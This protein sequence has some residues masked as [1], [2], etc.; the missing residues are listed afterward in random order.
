MR[1]SHDRADTIRRRAALDEYVERELLTSSGAFICEHAATCELSAKAEGRQ[2][3]PGEMPCMG[4]YYSLVDENGRPRR[5][6]VMG[7]ERG[8]AKSASAAAV[9]ARGTPAVSVADRSRAIQSYRGSRR[10]TTHINGTV[11]GLVTAL[12]EDPYTGNETV[13]VDGHP[14]H[15]LDAFVLTNSTLCSAIAKDGKGQATSEMKRHCAAHARRMMN[16]W[17][18]TCLIGQGKAAWQ[19]IESA[20]HVAVKPD[21][22]SAVRIG[23]TNCTVATL[24]HPTSQRAGARSTNWSSAN[25]EYF[26]K[27]VVQLLQATIR[28]EA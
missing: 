11:Y 28:P 9:G 16:I 8:V 17:E 10:A 3:I 23:A 5:I 24:Y 25:R 26:R 6:V 15:V 21:Q 13:S 7:Q 22:L 18:P 14:V 4:D 2:F 12:G 1:F 27:T 19:S 20:L